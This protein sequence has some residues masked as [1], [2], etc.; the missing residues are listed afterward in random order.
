MVSIKTPVCG[1]NTRHSKGCGFASRNGI[2]YWLLMYFH[3]PFYYEV[4]SNDGTTIISEDGSAGDCL[5]HPPGSVIKHGPTANMSVGFMNDWIYFLGDDADIIVRE[6][7][8]PVNK[9]FHIGQ[10]SLVGDCIRRIIG[11]HPQ[12]PNMYKLAVSL[13]IAGLLLDVAKDIYNKPLVE[14]PTYLH[15]T[16]LRSDMLSRYGEEWN[17]Q[18]LALIS[19][20]SIS[21]FSALYSNYFGISPMADLIRVRVENARSLLMYSEY[22]IGQIA[23]LCGFSSIQYFS[24]IYHDFTGMRP[25]DVRRSK[26]TDKNIISLSKE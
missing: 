22:S 9:A 21:R 2:D 20:Y 4:K 3:T 7:N 12:C 1:V 5:L 6:L 17:L 23:D 11:E 8:L 26:T 10:A 15:F 24:R 18:R 14:D 16:E 19:G 13:D 25:S